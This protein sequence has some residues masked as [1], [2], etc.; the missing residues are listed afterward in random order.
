MPNFTITVGVTDEQ[1]EAISRVFNPQNT[2][3]AEAIKSGLEKIVK[4]TIAKHTDAEKRLAARQAAKS[5]TE[6]LFNSLNINCTLGV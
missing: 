3:P 4:E 5:E 6:E 2:D 1:F